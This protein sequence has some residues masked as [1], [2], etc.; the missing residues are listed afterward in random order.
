MQ[1][2]WVLG[3]AGYNRPARG[4]LEDSEAAGLS[5]EVGSNGM[6]SSSICWIRVCSTCAARCDA[7]KIEIK[8][9]KEK[10]N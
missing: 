1:S 3:A 8:K 9:K 6:L 4:V 7:E 10:I 2:T 5:G